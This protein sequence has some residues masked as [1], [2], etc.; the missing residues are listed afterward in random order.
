MRI[1]RQNVHRELLDI[2][3]GSYYII[4]EGKKTQNR[5][6]VFARFGSALARAPQGQLSDP[7]CFAYPMAKSNKSAFESI[8]LRRFKALTEFAKFLPGRVTRPAG[9]G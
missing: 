7:N 6:D 4:F 8:E 5:K 3:L 9:K 2:L 1:I